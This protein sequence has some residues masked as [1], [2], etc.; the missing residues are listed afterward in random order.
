MCHNNQFSLNCK[1]I[2]LR[3]ALVDGEEDEVRVLRGVSER[4]DLV[5]DLLERVLVDDARRA[6]LLES[7]VQPTD[8]PCHK[9]KPRLDRIKFT[10]RKRQTRNLAL[11]QSAL[12][13][14]SERRS[15]SAMH[16]EL[17]ARETCEEDNR[18]PII[19]I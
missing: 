14:L 9:R 11:F 13:S 5:V 18:F 15:L 8:L 10:H 12:L 6:V 4:E 3:I 7:A 1:S 16:A 2:Q 17:R 19:K